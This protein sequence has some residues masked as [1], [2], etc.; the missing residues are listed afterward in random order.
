MNPALLVIASFLV[1]SLVLGLLARRG[2]TMNL[3]QW[4]VGGRGFGAVFVFLLMAGEI[5]TTFTFLGGSGWAYGRGAPAFYIICYGAIAYAISY[6]LLPVI[7][8]Y[9]TQ[10]HLHSQPDFF[11]SKYKSPALGVLV[12]LVSVTALVPYLVL[13]LKG[14]GIIISET[15]NGS[16]SVAAAVWISVTALVTY[17][18]ISGVHGSAWT[19][20]VKDVLILGVAV[21]LGLYLPWHYYGGFGPM[22]EAIEHAK[23]GFL[24]LPAKGMSPSWFVSTVLLSS[25]GFYMWPHAFASAYTAKSESVFRKNAVV[26]PL[27]QLVLLF[28]FFTGFAAILQTPGLVG[29]QADLSLLRISKLAFPPL[30]VGLIGGAGLLTALVPGSMILMTA[31]TILAKNV[32]RP[33]APAT[34]EQAVGR[35]ARGLVPV[36]ALVAVFFTLRG[37]DA[38]VPLLLLGY[39]LVTQLFPSLILSLPVRPLATRAG[40][41]AGIVAGVSTIAWT[42]LSGTTL[43]KLFP[44]WPSVVTDLNI[45]IVAMSVNIVVLLA[46]SAATRERAAARPVEE[47]LTASAR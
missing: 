47:R 40:S 28:V 37:G 33:L 1:L 17:V 46:V 16:L 22:F 44:T 12:A 7:W 18:V 13:Q 38:I 39:N 26:M 9:A 6:F 20:V 32:Y 27:Y 2:R 19:A 25:L 43:A 45:G 15:S 21:G 30:L 8:R 4:S 31:A 36:I 24:T 41:M 23:P 29:A 35:L 3:E 14:L 34:S 11:V 42:S 10:H 5:Y